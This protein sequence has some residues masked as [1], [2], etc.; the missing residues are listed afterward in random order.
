VIAMKRN[1]SPLV[2][3]SAAP[4]IGLGKEGRAGRPTIVGNRLPNHLYPDGSRISG[5]NHENELNK[6]KSGRFPLMSHHNKAAVERMLQAIV[7]GSESTVRTCVT[8]NWVN[9]DPS[10]PPLRGLEGAAE[11]ARLWRTGFSNLK[12]EIEDSIEM[13]DKVACRFRVSGT[14]SGPLMG[15]PGSGRPVSVVATGIF[16]ISDGKLA[17]NWVNF[18]ALGL[19]QQIGAV[20]AP[21]ETAVP[22]AATARK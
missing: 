11:L 16:R 2:P 15:I 12:M 1:M 7:S 18:D 17:D 6:I 4:A 19:L 5:K 20:P 9:H 8:P 22:S 21:G 13:E 14:H 10:L 3:P